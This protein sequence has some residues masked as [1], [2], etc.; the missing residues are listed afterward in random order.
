MCAVYSIYDG[1]SEFL[2]CASIGKCEMALSSQ[3][4]YVLVTPFIHRPSYDPWSGPVQV[5]SL[6]Y[7]E[8]YCAVYYAI[9]CAVYFPI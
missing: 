8:S 5:E 4:S 2:H 1:M 9:C 7:F 6:M 3:V